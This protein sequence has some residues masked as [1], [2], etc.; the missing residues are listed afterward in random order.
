MGKKYSIVCAA[1]GAKPKGGELVVKS[2]DKKR[3]D[4]IKLGGIAEIVAANI[5]LN[6]GLETRYTVLG[7]LQ[8]GGTPTPFDRILSTK[9]GTYAINL[10]YKK[11]FGRMAALIGNEVKSVNIEE[12]IAKQKLVKIDTQAVLA[13]KAVGASFGTKDL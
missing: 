6:T 3:T 1:E 10:A 4:P 13:A 5:E 8:R 2:I 12:A 11:K 7:H 9:F